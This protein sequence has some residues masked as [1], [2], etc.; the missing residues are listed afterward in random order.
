MKREE[1]KEESETGIGKRR[2]EDFVSVEVFEILSQERDVE[3]CGAVSWEDL[4]EE[5]DD[6][7]DR[8][9]VSCELVRVVPDVIDVPGYPSS[10]VTELCDVSPC[11]SDWEFV[12][13]QSFFFLQKKRAHCLLYRYAGRGEVRRL[14]RESASAFKKKDDAACTYSEFAYLLCE[15]PRKV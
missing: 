4:L 13:P 3:S 9:L 1:E 6:L 2:C 14:T 10:V 12:E 15:G 11:C 7:S 5:P 8:E